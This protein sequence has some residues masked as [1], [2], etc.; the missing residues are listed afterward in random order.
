MMTGSCLC[1]C[2]EDNCTEQQIAAL[3][4][5]LVEIDKKAHFISWDEAKKKLG[6]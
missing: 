4:C 1:E 6:L 5:D 3:E 2:E